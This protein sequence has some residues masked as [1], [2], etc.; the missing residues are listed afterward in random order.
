MSSVIVVS[1]D[2]LR[3]LIREAVAEAMQDQNG[4]ADEPDTLLSTAQ[5]CRRLGIGRTTLHE[6]RRR[7]RIEAVTIGRAVRFRASDVDALMN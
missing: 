4:A 2:E 3:T 7:G 6:M 5:V 1:P